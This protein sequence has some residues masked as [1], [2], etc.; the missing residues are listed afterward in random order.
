MSEHEELLF[1]EYD[2]KDD[3]VMLSTVLD[4]LLHTGVTINGDL[5]LGIADM[6]LMYCGIRVLL[7][8]VDT[9]R[10]ESKIE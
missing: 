9:L 6:D 3:K 8:S 7:T 1:E 10:K 2:P 5:I 4:K